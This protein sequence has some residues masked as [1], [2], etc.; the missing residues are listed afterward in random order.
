VLEP[1]LGYTFGVLVF[2]EQ[3][4]EVVHHLGGLTRAE[5]DIFRKIASKLYR[6]P[7]YAREVMGQWEVP[8]KEGFKS[9]RPLVPQDDATS[10]HGLGLLP[11]VLGLFASTLAHAAGYSLL[12]YRDMWLKTYYPREFYAAFLSKGLSQITKKRRSR[13][14]R[15]RA[16]LPKRSAWQDHAARHQRERPRLHGRRGGIRLGLEAIK[17][18]G[19][20]AAAAIEEHRPVRLLPGLRASASRSRPATRPARRRWS[21]PVPSIAGTCATTT[22]RSASTSSSATCS[23]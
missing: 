3:L 17:N 1:Y 14:R 18:I 11:L 12:A 6:D 10:R 23:A 21:W 15:P 13:S 8:I 22:P 16:R 4:I 2:Q 20:A 9:Q 7:S 5:A 19:P